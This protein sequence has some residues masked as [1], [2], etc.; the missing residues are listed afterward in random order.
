[1][2]RKVAFCP[3]SV[4]GVTMVAIAVLLLTSAAAAQYTVSGL[5]E[6]PITSNNTYAITNTSLIAQGPDGNLYMTDQLDGEY[7]Q[8]SVYSI[9]PSGKFSTVYSFCKEGSGC[10]DTGAIPDG[11]VTLGSNGNFYGTVQNGGAYGFGQVFKVTPEGVHTAVYNF[12]GANPGDGGPSYFPA[13]LSSDGDLWG[14]QTNG[15]GGVFKLT[16]KGAISN[17]PFSCSNGSNPN[18]PTQGSDGNFYGTT[19]RGGDAACGG[20]GL[21]YKVTPAGKITVLY[22]FTNSPSDGQYPQGVLVE[23]PDGN[24][25]GVTGGQRYGPDGSIFKISA[26]G[27]F[28]HSP[29]R[30]TTAHCQLPVSRWGATV[31]FMGQRCRVARGTMQARSSECPRPAITAFSTASSQLPGLPDLVPVQ[32]YSNTPTESSMAIPAEILLAIPDFST[33]LT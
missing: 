27:K 11:G 22:T 29:V 3:K 19:A 25:W 12:T 6:Y 18:L 33:V 9:S 31:T 1:M 13:F 32:F 20:C 7:S 8:G 26:S 30:P 4:S 24:Y 14:I 21:V 2:T 15:C 5:Y 10:V 17:Y 28:T 23:G 16:L